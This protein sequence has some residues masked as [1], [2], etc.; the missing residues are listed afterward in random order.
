MRRPRAGMHRLVVVAMRLAASAAV[1]MLAAA[2]AFG[3]PAPVLA[4]C[5]EVVPI[6]KAV[7]IADVVFV[8]TVT[9]VT[10]A[11]RWATV[12]VKEIWRG[13]DLAPEV[14]VK[15]GPDANAATSI[16]RT[17]DVGQTYIFTLTGGSA[18]ELTDD[19][20]SA[21]QPWSDVVKALQPADPRPP[22]GRPAAGAPLR[23]GPIIEVVGAALVAAAAMLVVGL[24]AR[25]RDPA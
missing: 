5:A 10:N 15:G 9:S 13:P 18:T 6:A 24:L 12:A 2:F 3:L 7:E 19:A 17:F 8:G 14:V 23:F 22:T 4:S 20:C 25:G 11:G 21:T 1:T 16:D